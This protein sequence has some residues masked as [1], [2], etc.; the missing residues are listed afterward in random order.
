MDGSVLLVLINFVSILVLFGI[1]AFL[2]SE[3]TRV[4]LDMEKMKEYDAMNERQLM[5]LIRDINDND[6][7]LQRAILRVDA[8]V[9]VVTGL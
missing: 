5:N 1:A 3:V 9:D 4:K 6:I 2:V 8:D 7:K